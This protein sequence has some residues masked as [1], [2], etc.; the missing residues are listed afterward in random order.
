LAA[1][2]ATTGIWAFV[3]LDRTPD[4]WPAMRW[5]V[6][7]GSVIVAAVLALGA[8]RLGRATA[9][10]AVGAVLFGAGATAA[11]TIETATNTHSGPMTVSGPATDR[12]FDGRGPDGGQSDNP[13]LAALVDGAE[14]RWAAA[15]VGSMT[16]SSL[17]LKTG[18]SIMA[19]GGFAGSD[20]S[21]TLAQF[22]AYVADGQVRYFIASDRGGP[23]G[24]RS[25]NSSEIT[26][27]VQQNFTPIDVGGTTVYDLEKGSNA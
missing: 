12:G 25:G 5:I 22:Q 14:N 2:S 6:L 9:V 19:I 4:W 17:E 21:P 15:T 26:T 20:N 1:M 18:A 23:P 13:A 10:V 24:D 27:W 3:L 8:H 11:Y 16:A 7:A